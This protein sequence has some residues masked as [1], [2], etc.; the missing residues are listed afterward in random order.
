MRGFLKPRMTGN[1]KGNRSYPRADREIN[2][3]FQLQAPKDPL[4][5][6]NPEFLE[7]IYAWMRACKRLYVKGLATEKLR[8]F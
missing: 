3:Y 5:L 1:H 6:F 7:T 4:G 8:C 2:R